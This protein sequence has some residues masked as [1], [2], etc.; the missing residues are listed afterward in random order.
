MG[1]LRILIDAQ[2]IGYAAYYSRQGM[3][4]PGE[5]NIYE[6]WFR[7]M[8]MA[9]NRF[10]TM[11]ILFCWDSP[12]SYRKKILPGY[13]G[14]RNKKKTMEEIKELEIVYKQFDILRTEILPFMGWKNHA[15]QE[16]Y[17]ADD[18]IAKHIKDNPDKQFAIVSG[19]EDLLQCLSKNVCV[20]RPLKHKPL[21]TLENLEEEHACTP[22]TWRKAK[23]LA[24][25]SSDEVPGIAGVGEATAIKY[26]NGW[27][28]PTFKKYE[29]IQ[30]ERVKTLKRNLPIV[31]LPFSHKDFPPLESFV[32]T[33]PPLIFPKRIFIAY[34][35][36]ELRFLALDPFW[37]KLCP[38]ISLQREEG[39]IVADHTPAKKKIRR[40]VNG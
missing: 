36:W 18:L 40:K 31:T 8:T 16:G 21:Y 14:S 20:F 10:G 30:K 27:L 15:M 7:Y 1:N 3:K 33:E 32:I 26:F 13:K 29:L 39:E 28:S 19:D 17:E 9:M 25:C 4:N 37:C 35:K 34:R 5:V 6:N 22:D 38:D 24:G 2:N 11:D 12:S 23:A